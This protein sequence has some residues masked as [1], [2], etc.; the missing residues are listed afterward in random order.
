MNPNE[1]DNQGPKVKKSV[2]R[3]VFVIG[4]RLSYTPQYD[5]ETGLDQYQLTRDGNLADGS[6]PHWVGGDTEG[7]MPVHMLS[8]EEQQKYQVR[9]A[10]EIQAE[11]A[12]ERRVASMQ[13]Q[14]NRLESE[15]GERITNERLSQ[16]KTKS[17]QQTS[18]QNRY[19][20]DGYDS[21]DGEYTDDDDEDDDDRDE[22]LE[23]LSDRNDNNQ[24]RDL[25]QDQKRQLDFQERDY[26]G[27]YDDDNLGGG[28]GGEEL[29]NNDKK[30]LEIQ[31]KILDQRE[32]A[33]AVFSQAMAIRGQQADKRNRYSGDIAKAA[34]RTVEKVRQ[35][36]VATNEELQS[37]KGLADK[38]RTQLD[39]VI[40]AQKKRKTK[41]DNKFIGQ[42]FTKWLNPNIL[43]RKLQ[44]WYY[45]RKINKLEGRISERLEKHERKINAARE[46]MFKD[47]ENVYKKGGMH[48][49]DITLEMHNLKKTSGYPG[50][51][52]P[53]KPMSH[54]E[55]LR[56]EQE[57]AQRRQQDDMAREQLRQRADSHH[58]QSGS[59][60]SNRKFSQHAHDVGTA[61]NVIRRWGS[62]IENDDSQDRKSSDER[63]LP[64]S[65]NRRLDDFDSLKNDD[66][67]GGGKIDKDNQRRNPSRSDQYKVSN[68]YVNQHSEKVS[69]NSSRS[70]SDFRKYDIDGY[71]SRMSGRVS[72]SDLR[73][74]DTVSQPR[75]RDND[76]SKRRSSFTKA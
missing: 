31:N 14:S 5:I 32:Q 4:G 43:K 9:R 75:I 11:L 47:I 46:Q 7:Y 37:Y 12:A 23:R 3:P 62:I 74:N 26:D 70:S 33:Q 51:S 28:E 29:N 49:E 56:L 17:N 22:E 36:E 45:N 39:N 2:V 25:R 69:K 24:R 10:K 6:R 57:V 21:E 68:K 1:T 66:R 72:P 18:Q 53:L 13:P 42:I 44:K 63:R 34:G 30:R 76:T 19:S 65:N 48:P 55:R 20:N 52:R 64:K 27:E 71:V 73:N 16:I 61:G 67:S 15:Q 40:A 50:K 58:S 60:N 41:N 35:I 54:N 8:Q 38:R 59:S